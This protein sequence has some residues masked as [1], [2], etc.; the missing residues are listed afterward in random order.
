MRARYTIRKV[1]M[2]RYKV[3]IFENGEWTVF[4]KYTSLAAVKRDCK[5]RGMILEKG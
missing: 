5:K 2:F 4:D 3:E 1:G